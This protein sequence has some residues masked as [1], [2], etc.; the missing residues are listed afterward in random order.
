MAPIGELNYATVFLDNA[1]ELVDK[2]QK[3]EMKLLLAFVAECGKDMKARVSVED[4]AKRA[5]IG[6]ASAYKRAA[7]LASKGLILRLKNGWMVSAWA[8]Y[9]GRLYNLPE[10]QSAYGAAIRKGAVE[11]GGPGPGPGCRPARRGAPARAE[12]PGEE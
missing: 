7:S 2:L 6:R 8:F 12:A 3:G 10:V 9:K 1:I 4:A 5:G 11:G